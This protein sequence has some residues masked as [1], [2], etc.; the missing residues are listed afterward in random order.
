VA[1]DP[2]LQLDLD[3]LRLRVGLAALECVPTG[4]TEEQLLAIIA[5]HVAESACLLITTADAYNA[6]SRAQEPN[7]GDSPPPVAETPPEPKPAPAVVDTPTPEPE[8]ALSVPLTADQVRQASREEH[9]KRMARLTGQRL[10]N[11][12]RLEEPAPARPRL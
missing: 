4:P 6:D 3:L 7:P 10:G 1:L 9:A 8:H 2:E 12:H 5:A 11:R